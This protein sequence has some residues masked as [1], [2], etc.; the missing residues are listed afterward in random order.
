MDGIPFPLS[1][2]YTHTHTLSLSLS[3]AL[4][5]FP[6]SLSS[7]PMNR[8][9]PVLALQEAPKPLID[10]AAASP[11]ASCCLVSS[12]LRPRRIAISSISFKMSRPQL[13]PALQDAVG[14]RAVHRAVVGGFVVRHY[15]SASFV[16][17]SRYL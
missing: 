5:Y 17:Y 6:H 12:T 4:R 2:H 8:R 7:S 14:D 3:P 10:R 15:V 1:I 11:R 9:R 16:S 13:T